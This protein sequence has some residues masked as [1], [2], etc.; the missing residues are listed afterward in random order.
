MPDGD[1]DNYWGAQLHLQLQEDSRPPWDRAGGRVSG[2]SFRITGS[3]IEEESFNVGTP[4]TPEEMYPGYGI[5][6]P[7]SSGVQHN[8]PFASLMKPRWAPT[9]PLPDAL[10]FVGIVWDISSLG[11]GATTFDFCVSEIRLIVAAE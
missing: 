11:E 3:G 2:L 8:I 5:E 6:R 7:A 4:P 10:P 9:T 1:F